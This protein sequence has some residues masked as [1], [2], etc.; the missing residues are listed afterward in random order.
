MSGTRDSGVARASARMRHLDAGAMTEMARALRHARR[1]SEGMRALARSQPEA[2]C[3]LSAGGAS[4]AR[5]RAPAARLH[6]ANARRR[7]AQ[8]SHPR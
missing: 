5:G 6:Q 7:R 3:G 1:E 8:P 2:A 4:A